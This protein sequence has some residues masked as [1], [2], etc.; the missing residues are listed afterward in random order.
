MISDGGICLFGYLRIYDERFHLPN[1]VIKFPLSGYWPTDYNGIHGLTELITTWPLP[2]DKLCWCNIRKMTFL[3]IKD[4]FT[5]AYM[6]ILWNVRVRTM[7]VLTECQMHTAAVFTVGGGQPLIIWAGA[8]RKLRKKIG[9]PSFRK[10]KFKGLSPG[11]NKFQRPFRRTK[12]L[13]RPLRGKKI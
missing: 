1:R 7:W 4:G 9:R 6:K 8:Q 10:K 11:K 3:C 5:S 2:W 13:E 12:N